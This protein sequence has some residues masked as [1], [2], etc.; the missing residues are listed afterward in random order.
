MAGLCG[1]VAKLNL[2]D[3]S[4]E[5]IISMNHSL[6]H[7]G[8]F[9]HFYLNPRIKLGLQTADNR[10][11]FSFIHLQKKYTLLLDG[12]IE[13]REKIFDL[14]K[15][16]PSKTICDEE[17][18][19]RLYILFSTSSFSYLE[20][21]YAFVLDCENVTYF[22]R[23]RIGIKPL[24]YSPLKNRFIFGSQIKAILKYPS[25]KAIVNRTTWMEMFAMGPAF[26]PTAT[27]YEN[28]YMIHPGHYL[29]YDFSG[30]KDVE[31]YRIPSW[32]NEK[33]ENQLIEEAKELLE[34]S[35]KKQFQDK[36]EFGALLSGG[37]DSSIIC[38]ILS[39]IEPINTYYLDFKN[40]EKHFHENIFQPDRDVHFANLMAAS[41]N[42][43]H[44]E[45]VL[46]ESVLAS[47]LIDSMIAR[48]MPSMADIDSS[49][50]WLAKVVSKKQNYLFSGECADELFG[51]YP[52]FYQ[53]FEATFPWNRN[54]KERI[55]LLNK[56]YQDLP[57]EEFVKEK[58]EDALKKIDFS[59]TNSEKE[60]QAKIITHLNIY[61]F[62]QNLIHRKD[63]QTSFCSLTPLVP[64]A[65]YKLVE[66][67]YNLPATYKYREQSEKWILK[68][69]FKE[70]LPLE[71]IYRKKNPFPKTHNPL[72][73][74]IVSKMLQECLED[75]TSIL[76]ELFNKQRLMEI[77]KDHSFEIAWFGQLMAKPQLIAYLVQFHHWQ[78]LYQVEFK[79]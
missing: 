3:L 14:L 44:H 15:I 17:L 41:L 32:K 39:K 71:I 45:C 61:Y 56:K 1:I 34:N 10:P 13:N 33:S 12:S 42:S 67:A 76:N 26:S 4:D 51:G 20:G 79:I 40:S 54:I 2:L 66:F 48:D 8:K 52:W 72:Y 78:K 37:L 29:K 28:I 16:S 19:I 31:Y 77:M 74:Q 35:V 53:K 21:Q 68:Q 55:T 7:R 75:E 9:S 58:Y 23:D 57:Y 43:S 36:K 69:A 6:S 47:L 63:S 70:E 73:L 5:V 59:T 64:F 46:E 18:I 22:V 24:Y 38:S 60:K 27:P 50:L 65:D 62:M 11:I 25:I 30:I 49:L